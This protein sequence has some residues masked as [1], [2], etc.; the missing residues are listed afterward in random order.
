MELKL[1]SSLSVATRAAYTPTQSTDI[2]DGE[3]VYAWVDDH[4]SATPAVSASEWIKAWEL[5]ALTVSTEHQLNGT[6]KYYPESGRN[7]DIY[8]L[9]G[10]NL[11]IGTTAVTDGANSYPEYDNT[12]ATNTTVSHTVLA[13]QSVAGNYEKSDLL[14]AKST[15]LVRQTARHPLIFYHMLSKIE[16]GLKLGAGMNATNISGA[17]IEIMNTKPTA[18]VQFSKA[19]AAGSYTSTQITADG[20][21]A[22]IKMRQTNSQGEITTG[23]T[24]SESGIEIFGEAIIVPQTITHSGTDVSFIHVHLTGGGDLYAKLGATTTFAPYKKYIYIVTLGLSGLTVSSTILD[25]TT[26]ATNSVNASME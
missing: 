11:T 3:K 2:V 22:P 17:T 23:P 10:N 24:T 25:W 18:K 21:A 4:G 6:T 16:V 8:A 7:V 15:D 13:D 1:S 20:T 12:D 14:Y 9:H 26:E 19:T 5:T